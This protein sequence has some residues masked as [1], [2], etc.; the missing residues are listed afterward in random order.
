LHAWARVN[1]QPLRRKKKTENCCQLA[2]SKESKK[3]AASSQQEHRH[4]IGMCIEAKCVIRDGSLR[5][6]M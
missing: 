3:Q 6:M 5:Q 2:A 1:P 4:H